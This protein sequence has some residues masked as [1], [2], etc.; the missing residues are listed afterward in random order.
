[1]RASELR[2]LSAIRFL[3]AFSISV[4]CDE[5]V[6]YVSKARGEKEK[7]SSG[8]GSSFP[9]PNARRMELPNV[10]SLSLW[11]ASAAPR[12]LFRA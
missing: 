5:G 11:A 2:H 4:L 10:R 6:A 7:E 12:K 1:M 9:R 3:H 8:R